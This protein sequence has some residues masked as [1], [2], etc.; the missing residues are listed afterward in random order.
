MA[1]EQAYKCGRVKLDNE[2]LFLHFLPLDLQQQYR[3]KRINKNPRRFA[4]T[5]YHKNEWQQTTS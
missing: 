3:Y 2:I 1:L 4:S 5:H